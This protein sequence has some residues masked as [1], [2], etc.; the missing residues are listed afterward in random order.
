MVN[1]LRIQYKVTFPIFLFSVHSEEHVPGDTA[2]T[3]LTGRMWVSF[4]HCFIV[5]TSLL[6]LLQGFVANKP[7]LFSDP[8]LF[9]LLMIS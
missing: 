1:D 7:A 6:L 2:L 8:K 4:Y 5:W 3:H 9:S